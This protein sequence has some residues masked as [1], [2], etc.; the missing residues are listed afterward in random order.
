MIQIGRQFSRTDLVLAGM[1]AI[2]IL[3]GLLAVVLEKAENRMIKGR[4][5][6]GK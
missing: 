2:G 3:G 5:G 6:Y 4:Q 1:I